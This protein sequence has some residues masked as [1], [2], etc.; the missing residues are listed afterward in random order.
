LRLHFAST[1]DCAGSIEI[2]RLK[3][4]KVTAMEDQ[5]IVEQTKSLH[6]ALRCII[7]QQGVPNWKKRVYEKITNRAQSGVKYA[8]KKHVA[9]EAKQTEIL[10]LYMQFVNQDQKYRFRPEI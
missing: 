3:R 9:K 7:V 5:L 1:I 2:A 6:L 4:L 10:V 8:L